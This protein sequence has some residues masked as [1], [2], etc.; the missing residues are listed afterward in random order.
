MEEEI[1][2]LKRLSSEWETA[3]GKRADDVSRERLSYSKA[4][5]AAVDYYTLTSAYWRQPQNVPDDDGGAPQLIEGAGLL[6]E[7]P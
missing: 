5:K 4:A 6:A 3:A 1:Q 2:R 7:R